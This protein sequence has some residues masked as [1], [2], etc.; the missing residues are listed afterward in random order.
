MQLSLLGELDKD[1]GLWILSSSVL[2]ESLAWGVRTKLQKVLARHPH[3]KGSST[4]GKQ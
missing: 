2:E 4:L 3:P 1:L